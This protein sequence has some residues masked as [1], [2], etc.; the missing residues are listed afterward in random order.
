MFMIS[1]FS[2]CGIPFISGFYSKDQILEFIFMRNLNFI[3]Y[4]LLILSTGLTVSYIIRMLYYLISRNFNCYEWSLIGTSVLTRYNNR[5][6]KVHD[7]DWNNTPM[8][9]FKKGD[10]DDPSGLL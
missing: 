1:N 3:I 7:I 10:R 2:L 8:F 6:Y 9:T 4:L 5:T